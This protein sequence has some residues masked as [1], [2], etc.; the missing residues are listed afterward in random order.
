MYNFGLLE[1]HSVL[2]LAQRSPK[3]QSLNYHR[4]R[5]P[6]FLRA[7]QRRETREDGYKIA[8]RVLQRPITPSYGRAVKLGPGRVDWEGPR[9]VK[10]GRASN[11]S[12]DYP[13]PTKPM[14]TARI[15]AMRHQRA[16]NMGL[17]EVRRRGVG[18][19]GVGGGGESG[20]G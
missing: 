2:A 17:L 16:W 1:F 20:K 12:R 6:L 19:G 13:L 7:L 4:W 15:A 9:G 11:G 8:Y 14:K 3:L 5:S 10:G 18:E